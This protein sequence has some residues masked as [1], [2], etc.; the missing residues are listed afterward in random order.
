MNAPWLKD[1]VT[2]EMRGQGE[3]S[4]MVAG[5]DLAWSFANGH[6]AAGL[7]IGAEGVTAEGVPLPADPPVP[8]NAFTRR[9]APRRNSGSSRPFTLP[10]LGRAAMTACERSA[11]RTRKPA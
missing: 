10:D 11:S 2:I 8:N 6:R 5:N 1:G 3:P 9:A 7:V 4:G